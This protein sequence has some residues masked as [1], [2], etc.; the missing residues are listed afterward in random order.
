MNTKKTYTR[1]IKLPDGSE[2]VARSS[3]S[4]AN[5]FAILEDGKFWGWTSDEAVGLKNVKRMTF[6]EHGVITFVATTLVSVA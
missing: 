3:I 1:S 2:R 5:T 6:G 4:Y